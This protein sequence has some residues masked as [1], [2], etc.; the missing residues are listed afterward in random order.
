MNEERPPPRSTSSLL[1]RARLNE[2]AAEGHVGGH[3]LG[4]GPLSLDVHLAAKSLHLRL[5]KK[6]ERQ[7]AALHS[8]I[9]FFLLT[10]VLMPL[11]GR[12]AMGRRRAR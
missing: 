5:T 10:L 8:T 7:E 1:Q 11:L 3:D 2:A 9:S 6:E 4:H 12:W